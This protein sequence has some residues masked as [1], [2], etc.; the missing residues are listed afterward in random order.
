MPNPVDDQEQKGASASRPGYSAEPEPVPVFALAGEYPSRIADA[1]ERI[2]AALD[3]FRDDY[4]TAYE[5]EERP[6]L[7]EQEIEVSIS[8]VEIV[9]SAVAEADELRKA[10]QRA[11]WIGQQTTADEFCARAV[12]ETREQAWSTYRALAEFS[13]GPAPCDG[14]GEA[15]ETHSGSTEGDS[16]VT[17]E[18]RQAPN[19]SMAAII[20]EIIERAGKDPAQAFLRKT[21]ERMRAQQELK[22]DPPLRQA[23]DTIKAL[24]TQVETLTRERDAARKSAQRLHRRCQEGEA[25]LQARLHHAHSAIEIRRGVQLEALKEIRALTNRALTAEAERDDLRTQLRAAH[26]A[27][28]DIIR[29]SAIKLMA[30]EMTKQEA[31]TA[32]AVANGIAAKVR[33]LL[34]PEKTEG[35]DER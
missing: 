18:V 31:R 17:D 32:Y 15:G 33:S 12:S 10:L 20:S 27:L 11:K 5:R 3:D 21:L 7:W 26:K 23:P 29:P 9:L 16:A 30:G 4:N 24:L 13:N 2:R 35:S 1:V 34:N 14:S 8:D 6:D 25:G 22:T 28:E 19:N